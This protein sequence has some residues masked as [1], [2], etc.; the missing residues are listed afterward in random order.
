MYL[1]SKEIIIRHA[2]ISDVQTLCKWWAD[3]EVMAH[4][5]FPNGIYTDS[6]KLMDSI[7]NETD[8]ARRLIIEID[9][10]CVGEMNYAIKDKVAEIGIKI[11]DFTYQEK[12]YGTK[13]LKMLIVYLFDDLKVEKIILDTNINNT[14]AQHVYEKLG[15]KRIATRINSFKNQLGV[16]QSSIDYELIKEDVLI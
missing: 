7:R 16:F 13:A 15:F 8:S 11:C 10:K 4:A 2:T 12:G 1:S 6:D 9:N 3:G 14:R 5:G